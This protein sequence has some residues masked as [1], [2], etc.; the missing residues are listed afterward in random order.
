ML[1]IYWF[2]LAT[3]FP[4]SFLMIKWFATNIWWEFHINYIYLEKMVMFI[5]YF[6]HYISTCS[7]IPCRNW[8]VL[9]GIRTSSKTLLTCNFFKLCHN[10]FLHIDKPHIHSHSLLILVTLILDTSMVHPSETMVM[11]I[12][13]VNITVMTLPITGSTAGR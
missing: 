13:I 1:S 12:M 5:T 6:I 10:A 2:Q 3:F 7:A 4:A 8:N 9:S 11:M